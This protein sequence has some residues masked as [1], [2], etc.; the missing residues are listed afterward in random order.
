VDEL[1]PSYNIWNQFVND[2]LVRALD[3][4]ALDN[5]HPIEVPVGHPAEI[6]EIFDA[7]SYSKGAS[8]LRMLYNYIGDDAFRKGMN[9]YLTRHSYKNAQ[10]EDL[11]D[12]LE[13]ASNK[14]VRRLMSTWTLQ[15]GFPV[16]TVRIYNLYLWIYFSKCNTF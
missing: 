12:A 4:D 8:I 5:S 15:K 10:T 14:P 1:F 6:D 7:I 13:E 11:W 3:L 16:I 2:E 9:L